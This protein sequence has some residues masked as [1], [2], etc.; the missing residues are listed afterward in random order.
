MSTKYLNAI[1]N[2]PIEKNVRLNPLVVSPKDSVSILVKNM[3]QENIGAAIVA[4]RDLPIGIITEKDILERV[5]FAKKKLE[6]TLVEDIMTKSPITIEVDRSIK[7]AMDL[8]HKS[9]IRRLIVT[10]NGALLGLITERRILQIINFR[11]SYVFERLLAQKESDEN[12]S[13]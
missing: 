2:T 11:V 1:Y 7:E 10:K 9:K 8:V 12:L 3:L 13:K 4:E 5:V 6:E